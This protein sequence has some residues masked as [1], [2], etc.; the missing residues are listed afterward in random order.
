MGRLDLLDKFRHEDGSRWDRRPNKRCKHELINQTKVEWKRES[1][2]LESASN[3]ACAACGKRRWINW[4]EP[5]EHPVD[6]NEAMRDFN[7]M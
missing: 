7:E 1:A 4:P 6:V 2:F 5:S 3:A